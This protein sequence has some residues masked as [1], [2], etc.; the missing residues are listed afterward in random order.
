[1]Y[2]WFSTIKKKRSF[3]ESTT[4]GIITISEADKDQRSKQENV[5]KFKNKSRPRTK[6]G[7]VKKAILFIV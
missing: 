1:M 5:L 4:R 3:G 7:K 6:E 2:I